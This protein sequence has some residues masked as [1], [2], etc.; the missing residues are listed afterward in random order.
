MRVQEHVPRRVFPGLWTRHRRPLDYAPEGERQAVYESNV[1]LNRDQASTSALR[2]A[3][4]PLAE[5]RSCVEDD[6][7]STSPV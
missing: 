1:G 5:L 7:A 2:F 3:H 4:E 6:G